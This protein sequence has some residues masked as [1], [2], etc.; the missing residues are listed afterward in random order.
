MVRLPQPGGDSGEWG[1]ILNEYLSQAH[2]DDGTL[3]NGSVNENTLTTAVRNKLNATPSVDVAHIT[4]VD[5]TA[6]SLTYLRGDGVWATPAGTGESG[7]TVTSIDITDATATGRDLITAANG[8]AARTVIGAGTAST[9]SDIGL[10]NV[11]NTSDA[12]K[13]AA[14]ATLTNKTLS[15]ASNVFSNIPQ[16]AITNLTTDLTGKAAATHTHTIGNV[17]GLQAALDAAVQIGV[18]SRTASYTLALTDANKALE[19]NSASSTTVTIPTNASVAFPVG[20]V[21][22]I[23]RVGAGAVTIAAAGGVTIQS[24]DGSLALRGQYSVASIRKRAT[25]TWL[26]AGDLA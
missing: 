3:R 15:G 22:E 12:T 24:A 20:T 18:T 6:S 16:S 13:N 2:E 5:G 25:D 19:M 23:A 14:A 11:D 21:I 7:G 26:L 9:K 17:T 10:G 8:P 4:T 1:S